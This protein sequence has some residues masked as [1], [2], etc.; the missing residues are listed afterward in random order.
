MRPTG[1]VRV[2]PQTPARQVASLQESLITDHHTAG[3][4][5]TVAAF[6]IHYRPAVTSHEPEMVR[7]PP[8][9]LSVTSHAQDMVRLPPQGLSV[10]SHVQNIARLPPQGLAVTSH[11]QDMVRLLPQGLPVT[12]PASP[13]PPPYSSTTASSQVALTPDFP[14]ARTKHHVTDVALATS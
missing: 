7:P 4:A 3:Q 6:G 12:S 1:P 5:T 10:T 11:A 13:R 14:S 9:R 2:Q 8:Q